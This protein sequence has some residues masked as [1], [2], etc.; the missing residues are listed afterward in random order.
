M[1]ERFSAL[2]KLRSDYDFHLILVDDGSNLALGDVDLRQFFEQ[3]KINASYMCHAENRGKGAALRSGI[4]ASEAQFTI[5]T[6]IDFPYENESV[7]DILEALLGGSDIAIGHREQDYY[8]SVPWFRK[9]M[10]EWFRFLLKKVLRF[11]IS[12]TQCGLKGMNLSG[13]K[14]FLQT[15]INRFLVDM[16]FIKRALKSPQ[17]K[18]S[19]VVVR[20]RS[21]VTFSKMGGSVILREG[22]NLLRIL[23]I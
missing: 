20:L 7:L 18:L 14:V 9:G 17:I 8:A 16:E 23:F 13:R 6:D 1:V 10:S 5:F 15:K 2:Q 19:T 11:P 3:K 4:A 22:I 21:D 12:D